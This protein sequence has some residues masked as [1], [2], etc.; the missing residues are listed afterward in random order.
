MDTQKRRWAAARIFNVEEATFVK[1]SNMF[2]EEHFYQRQCIASGNEV[3]AIGYEFQD[4]HKY[5]I[6]TN[7]WNIVPKESWQNFK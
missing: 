1:K 6:L 5:N 4:I 2:K 7:E 3:L